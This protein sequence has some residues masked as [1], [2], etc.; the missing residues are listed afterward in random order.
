MEV[1]SSL[2]MIDKS[3]NMIWSQFQNESTAD[4][5]ISIFPGC[6]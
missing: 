4:E 1:A 6:G 3:E 2:E 5:L